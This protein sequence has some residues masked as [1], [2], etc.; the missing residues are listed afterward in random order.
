MALPL[1]FLLLYPLTCPAC[2][3]AQGIDSK[4]RC[5]CVSERPETGTHQLGWTGR[6]TVTEGA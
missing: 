3:L 2:T 1:S 4:G 5:V 6:V